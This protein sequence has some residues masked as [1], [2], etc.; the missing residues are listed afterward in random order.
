MRTGAVY[1]VCACRRGVEVGWGDSGHLFPPTAL[2]GKR[3]A[4]S[5][6]SLSA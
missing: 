1:S 4:A 3:R 6:V 5:I 2:T